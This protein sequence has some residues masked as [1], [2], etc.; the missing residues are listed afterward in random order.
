MWKWGRSAGE[1][2]SR[3]L[4]HSPY[5]TNSVTGFIMAGVGDGLCQRYFEQE[6]AATDHSVDKRRVLEMGLIRAAIISPFT[7]KWYTT[8]ARM[9]PGATLAPVLKRVVFD[10]VI[11]SPT[12]I[13]LV[14]M[15]KAVLAGEPIFGTIKQSSFRT[16]VVGLQYLPISHFINFYYVPLKFQPLYASFS[17]VYWNAILSYYSN[18]NNASKKAGATIAVIDPVTTASIVG[19]QN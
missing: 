12:V 11:G 19:A 3:C 13:C 10:Q 16:W 2:Y 14:F 17:S 8:L 5:I 9:V 7:F 6:N 4:S 1:W 15:A 18:N